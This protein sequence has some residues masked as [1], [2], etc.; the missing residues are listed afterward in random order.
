[1]LQL[2]LMW[3]LLSEMMW[4]RPFEGM[5]HAAISWRAAVGA[6]VG[7]VVNAA[8]GPDVGS[9]V[10]ADVGEAVRGDAPCCNLV[11]CCCWCCCG[12][13][14]LSGLV[15]VLLSELVWA[16]RFEGMPPAAISWLAG[17]IGADVCAAVGADGVSASGCV[18]L[19]IAAVVCAAVG[20]DVGAD[21]GAVVRAAVEDYVGGY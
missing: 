8:V 19:G 14:L 15:W 21:V 20:A 6:A 10:G 9:A 1:M 18:W 7:A 16:M 3:V 13:W 11:V 5:P 4:A 12:C 2:G 17:V